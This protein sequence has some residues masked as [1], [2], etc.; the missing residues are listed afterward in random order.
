MRVFFELVFSFL[1]DTL[2]HTDIS[3]DIRYLVALIFSFGLFIFVF[4]KILKL[5]FRSLG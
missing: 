3:A 1:S 4:Y 5:F 2:V